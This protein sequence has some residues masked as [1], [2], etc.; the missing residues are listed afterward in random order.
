MRDTHTF[1]LYDFVWFRFGDLET[2]SGKTCY[3]MYYIIT[4]IHMYVILLIWYR[5]A[6]WLCT[7]S[8]KAC[9]HYDF[10]VFD[11]FARESLH[12]TS[13]LTVTRRPFILIQVTVCAALCL[14]LKEDILDKWP[15]RL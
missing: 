5:L 2:I 15:A 9:I 13:H 10:T 8:L 1:Y 11:G 7:F 4:R 6:E 14:A 12:H 3:N